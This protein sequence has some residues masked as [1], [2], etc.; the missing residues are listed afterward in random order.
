MGDRFAPD[1]VGAIYHDV[2]KFTNS[3]RADQT[4]DTHSTEFDTLREQPEARMGEGSGFADKR[5]P[6]LCTHH[7]ALSKNEKSMASASIQNTLESPEAASQMRPLF[8]P[9]GS[10]ARQDVL[11]AA[12]LAAASGEEDFVAWAA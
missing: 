2:V 3:K 11:L 10:A 9:R 12:D 6:V 5:P 4:M 7:A 1:A 8:G